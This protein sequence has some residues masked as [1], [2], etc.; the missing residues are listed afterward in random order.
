MSVLS[1]LDEASSNVNVVIDKI[2][3]VE[4]ESEQ[5]EESFVPKKPQR[6]VSKT[7]LTIIHKC[8]PALT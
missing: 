4:D 6:R 5:E 3:A 8:V 2:K 7:L 1:L